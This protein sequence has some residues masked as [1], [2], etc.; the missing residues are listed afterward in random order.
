MRIED[1]GLYKDEIRL[2]HQR[3]LEY[4][5]GHKLDAVLLS[6]RCNFSWYTSGS[7][8]FVGHAADVGNSWLLVARDGPV[9]LAN[10]IEA[11]RLRSEELIPRG[12]DV[13][14]WEWPDSAAQ[15]AT[16][17]KFTRGRKVAVDAP[18]P[19]L[20][21]PRLGGDF[22]RLRWQLLPSEI[23]RYR[24]VCGDVVA[25]IESAAHAAQPGQSEN[26]LAGTLSGELRR[27]GLLE[28]VILVAADER[29]RDFRHPL[30]TGRALRE[31]V[32]LVT[33]ADRGGLIAACS[34]IVSFGPLGDDLARRHEAVCTVDAALWSA[35][36]PGATL[37][38]IFAEAQEAYRQVG[39]PDEWRLHHQGGSIGYLPREVRCGPG[40]ATAAMENQAFAWN[41][42][43]AGAKSEDTIL[44]TSQGGQMLAAESTFPKVEVAWKGRTVQRAG[45][46]IR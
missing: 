39:Y 42:S 22:D 38:A 1:C 13:V 25:A 27:R 43:I 10:N 32:M 6:R 21:L 46:L 4:L 19:G 44:C 7:R 12:I 11:P 34:R 20:D 29:L 45:I 37:G 30:P 36:R 41:P 28:W 31:R 17:H 9:V 5:D 8:N 3:V 23:E 26:E 15:A 35:T 14:E 24:G 40:D 2:K 16:F 18:A 33:C